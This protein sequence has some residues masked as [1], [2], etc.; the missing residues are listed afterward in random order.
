MLRRLF[1]YIKENSNVIYIFKFLFIIL[2][3]TFVGC[4]TTQPQIKIIIIDNGYA[5]IN[6]NGILKV[7]PI[8]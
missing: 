8:K 7:V 3:F 5:M 2:I 6:D 1:Y 4:K